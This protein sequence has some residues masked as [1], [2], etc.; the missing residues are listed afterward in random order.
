L[1]GLAA[2]AIS[3]LSFGVTEGV[4]AS[5]SAILNSGFADIFDASAPYQVE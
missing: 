4:F 2:G 3:R 5:G 1:L